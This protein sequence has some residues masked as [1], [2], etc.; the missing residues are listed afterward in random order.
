MKYRKFDINLIIDVAILF[1]LGLLVLIVP[2]ARNVELADSIVVSKT[3]CFIYFLMVVLGISIF[4]FLSKKEISKIKISKIDIF[5]CLLVSYIMLNRYVIQIYHGFSIRFIELLGLIFLY[6]IL[7]S[8][9]KRQYLWLLLFMV[10]AGV[11]QAILGIL[12]AIGLFPSLNPNFGITGN[13]FNPGPF[14]GFLAAVGVLALAMYI[15]EDQFINEAKFRSDYK[16]LNRF[17]KIIFHFIPLLGLIIILIVLPATRSRT[18]WLSLVMG[19]VFIFI[20]R[21]RPMLFSWL[22]QYKGFNLYK[23]I[24][25]LIL[26]FGIVLSGLFGIYKFKEDSANGRLLIWKVSTSIVNEH[27][28]FGVGYDQF[29]AHFMNAQANYFSKNSNLAEVMLSDNTYYAFNYPIQFMV[30][31]GLIGFFL[32]CITGLLCL[33]VKPNT[34]DN[35]LKQ[36]ILGIF[37]TFVILGMFSYPSHILPI[38]ILMVFLLALLAIIDSKKINIQFVRILSSK[39]YISG[40]FIVCLC[41]TIIVGISYK[42]TVLNNGYK[43]WNQAL[44]TYNLGQYKNSVDQFKKIYPVFYKNGDFLMQYGKALEMIGQYDQAKSTLEQAKNYLNTTIIEIALGNSYKN[45]NRIQRAEK[46][47]QKAANM[48]P[49]KFYPEYLLAKLYNETGQRQKAFSKAMMVLTKEVKIPSKAIEEIRA[50]MKEITEKDKQQIKKD[51]PADT[52]FED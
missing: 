3:I 13:F 52:I 2:W 22:K 29:K 24:L 46:A 33:K 48:V 12:Q 21:Y 18:A 31:N 37:S 49:N 10:L 15:F 7:R 25:L 11:M 5:L 1:T 50:E 23:R 14:G 30:E 47:Y 44:G 16:N 19:C 17:T 28:V 20:Y 39:P 6:M 42:I 32:L 43:R 36:L 26:I 40:I 41:M 35:Y 34:K 38:K 4:K 27:P 8:I 9:S 45:L 51:P